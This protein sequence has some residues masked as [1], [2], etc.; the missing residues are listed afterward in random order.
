M[1]KTTTTTT[2]MKTLTCPRHTQFPFPKSIL[3]INH[4]MIHVGSLVGRCVQICITADASFDVRNTLLRL[5]I[6]NRRPRGY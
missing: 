1:A 5:K 4:Y 6:S 3:N 2:M